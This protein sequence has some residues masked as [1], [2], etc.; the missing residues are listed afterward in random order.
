MEQRGHYTVGE[1]ARLSGLTPK[2]LR[3]Y[4]QRGLLVP[5][6]SSPTGYRLYSEGQVALA[7]RIARLREVELPLETIREIV[8]LDDDLEIR[9][10]LSAHRTRLQSRSER[11]RHSLHA[12]THLINDDPGVL[13]SLDHTPP[14]PA[15]D[16]RSIAARLYNETWSLLQN[17]KR[18]ARDDDRMLHMAH[19]SRFHWDNV[20]TD[21]HR[22]IGEWQISRVH[23][24][25]GRGASAVF[26]AER[27][28]DYAQTAGVEVWVRASAHEG[29]ARAHAVAG[30]IEA[31]RQAR[32]E[33]LALLDAITDDDDRQ[34]IA[35][36]IESLP[37]TLDD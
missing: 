28:V 9:Q 37:L 11:V 20:G 8:A 18:T 13:M 2:A 14:E 31:A 5:V 17:D 1:V 25:L 33:S 22:S 10:M 15:D 34:V 29:L 24:A 19:A 32:D 7:R 27:A 21:Q 3:H 30:N 26:H 16:E 4:D 35:A 6:S 36:D 12:L 23:A